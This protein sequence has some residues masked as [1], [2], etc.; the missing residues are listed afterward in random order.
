VSRIQTLIESPNRDGSI[1]GVN[2]K[3]LQELPYFL[4]TNRPNNAVTVAANQASPMQVMSVSGE[5]P[6]QIV[7]F[8]HEKTQDVRVLM[9]LQNGNAISSLMNGAVHIDTIMGNAGQPYYLSEALYIDELR[10]LQITYTDIS[11]L[12]SS[13]RSVAFAQRY[14]TQTADPTLK[15]VKTRMKQRQYLSMPFWYTLDQGPVTLTAGETREVTITMGQDHHFEIFSLSRVATGRFNIAVVD[16]STG[17][18]L[19]SAPQDQHYPIGDEI[20]FGTGNFPF[21]Y[22]EPRMIQVGQRLLVTLVN[23][24]GVDNTI[25]LTMGGR[26][27]ALKMWRS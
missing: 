26:A 4:L 15:K 1:V 8:S 20:L 9:Q 10:S 17:E 18:S 24:A 3:R 21:R 16:Q 5:G 13:V 23:R 12:G 22:H 7:S 25:H 2:P 19:I 6:A 11:G 27:V 14:L